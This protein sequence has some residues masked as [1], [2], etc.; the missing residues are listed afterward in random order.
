MGWRYCKMERKHCYTSVSTILVAINPYERLPIYGQ[1]VINE[2]HDGQKKGRLPTNRPHPYCVSA[3]AYMRMVQRKKNQSVIVCGESGAGKTETTKLLMRYLAMTAPSASMESSMVEQQIIAASPILEAYGNAKTVMNNNSSRFGKFTKLLY[4]VPEKA[5][6][7]HIL[8]SYM[9]TYLLEKSRVVFQSQ[10]ER[11]YHIPYFLFKGLP[12]DKHAQFGILDPKQFYYANQGGA[13][14]VPGINDV[15]RYEE[16]AESLGLMRIDDVIQQ[17]LWSITMGIFNLGNVSFKREGDGFASID[18]KSQKYLEELARLWAIDAKAV[19]KRLTTANIKVMKKNIEKQIPFDDASTN[20]DSI[21]KGIYENVFLYLCERIN[22]E[23]YQTDEEDMKNIL[24]IGILDVFGF[25]NFYINSLEQFCINYTNEKLQQFFNYHIIKSEQEEYIRESVFW[26]PLTVPDNED[27]ITFVE[28][29]EYGFFKILDSAC[30]AP[31]PTCEAFMQDLFKRHGKNPCIKRVTKPGSGNARGGPAKKKKSKKGKS[32][33]KFDGFEIKHFADM[34]SYQI[35]KFLVKN[36]EA[37]HPDTAKMLK[38]S[39]T[40]LVK[41][42][43]GQGQKGK[44]KKS[45]TAVF[46]GGIRTLMKNL[47]S[48]EPYFVRCVNPN[49]VKSS[50]VWTESVVEHQLRCGGLVE[51][52]KVLKLGYPTRVPYSTLYDEYHGNLTNPLMKN[53]GP[54]TFSSALL[55]AFDVSEEDYELGL[56]KIFFKPAKAAVLDTIMSQAGQPLTAEQNK[57]IT[58]WV[59]QKRIRQMVGTARAY[60]EIRRRVRL[61]RAEARWRYSG[62]VCGILGGTVMRHLVIAR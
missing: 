4:D 7:G 60:L 22:A 12:N 47:K 48:T 31:K 24:Y 30:N 19:T 13:T 21:S 3:R 15:S 40:V 14:E 37:V 29:K 49:M 50:T 6:E 36:M 44:K 45:V 39:K 32:S 58:K 20:R 11:N 46:A 51:A 17:D 54:V 27:Y 1:D 57:K 16:L 59:V 55:I 26:T 8:G 56:T 62:R 38:K 9:E 42:I 34:V 10:N 5:R 18:P 35:D 28:D 23:L 43:G 41:E 2:F 53:M 25:E 52:L 33:N 61:A